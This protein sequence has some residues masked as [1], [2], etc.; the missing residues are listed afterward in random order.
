MI[1]S[2]KPLYLAIWEIGIPDKLIKLTRMEEAKA[3]GIIRI[4]QDTSEDFERQIVG[5]DDDLNLIARYTRALRE[6]Y[7]ELKQK[8]T[9][10]AEA[11]I[12]DLDIVD[13]VK[14]QRLRW[15]G[16]VARMLEERIPRRI[17][18]GDMIGYRTRGRPRTRRR[19]NVRNDAESMLGIRNW[20]GVARDRD[21]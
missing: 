14:I 10:I 5:C 15:A 19:D 3:K 1:V 11:D 6:R 8:S 4:Q 12:Q 16:Y 21:S 17:M 7:E 9:K 20:Q 13:F 2:K 18:R